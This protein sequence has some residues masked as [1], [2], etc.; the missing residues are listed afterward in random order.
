MEIFLVGIIVLAVKL[1]ELYCSNRNPPTKQCIFIAITSLLATTAFIVIPVALYIRSKAELPVTHQDIY[2][3]L[4]CLVVVLF[5]SSY[6]C[7]IHS[8]D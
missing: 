1:A 4:G 5:V 3:G 2:I 8:S 6:R 7:S